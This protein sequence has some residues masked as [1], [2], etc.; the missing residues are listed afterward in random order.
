M[1]A[2]NCHNSKDNHPGVQGYPCQY[3]FN[4]Y[5]EYISVSFVSTKKDKK[6]NVIDIYFQYNVYS[7]SFVLKT[8]TITQ[9][10]KAS[11]YFGA[12]TYA[13]GQMQIQTFGWGFLICLRV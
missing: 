11:D 5:N 10:Y 8:A 2:L 7:D 12:A 9:N 1:R 13:K 3:N 4:K 6:L